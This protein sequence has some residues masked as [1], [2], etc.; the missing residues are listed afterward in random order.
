M[1]AEG[2]RNRRIRNRMY[3]GEGGR[4][5]QALLL[6]DCKQFAVYSEVGSVVVKAKY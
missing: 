1:K 5:A 4:R 6:P 2:G 3:G